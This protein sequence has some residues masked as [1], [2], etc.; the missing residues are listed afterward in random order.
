MINIFKNNFMF[1]FSV[2]FLMTFATTNIIYDMHTDKNWDEII[3]VSQGVL[4]GHPPWRAFQNRLLM[5]II[6]SLLEG[7]SNPK[8]E[9]LFVY[10][11]GI[12]ITPCLSMNPYLLPFITGASSPSN[13]Q[14]SSNT[15]PFGNL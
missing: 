12:F 1:I 2:A 11:V 6:I 9:I 4:T 14:C 15:T 5:P 10:C 7:L 3:A 13:S 8:N